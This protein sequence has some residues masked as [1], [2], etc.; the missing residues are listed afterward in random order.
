MPGKEVTFS[1]LPKSQQDEFKKRYLSGE[2]I[3]GLCKEFGVKRGSAQYYVNK[4]WKAEKEL[5]RTELF[6]SFG[7]AKK[8]DFVEM[9][10][11]SIVIMKRA[12]EDLAR[13]GTPPT[14]MEAKRA[15]EILESLDKIT[16]LDE[17]KPTEIRENTVVTTEDLRKRLSVDPFAIEAEY[18]E[19]DEPKL[20]EE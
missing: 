17:N 16:R 3:L 7:E 18:E 5:L 14:I 13:R 2:S 12:L 11:S 19:I 10:Q 20:L 4:E 15:T 6:K 1:A 9:S 8:Q